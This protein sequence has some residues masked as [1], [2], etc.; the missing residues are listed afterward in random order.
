MQTLFVLGLF[1]CDGRHL[2]DS[3]IAE[4]LIIVDEDVDKV[5]VLWPL[6]SGCRKSRAGPSNLLE[7]P[8]GFRCY[9]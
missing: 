3:S 2:C 1:H 9:F 4:V 7:M 8:E 6:I 5:A